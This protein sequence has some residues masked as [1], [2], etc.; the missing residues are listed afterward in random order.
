MRHTA[1][2]YKAEWATLTG[3]SE[4]EIYVPEALRLESNLR[5]FIDVIREDGSERGTWSLGQSGQ[6]VGDSLT[7]GLARF[8]S[9]RGRTEAALVQELEDFVQSAPS[10]TYVVDAYTSQVYL[11]V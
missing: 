5:R 1:E 11:E 2:S 7:V 4:R 10:I 9:Y 6:R 8:Q 3:K